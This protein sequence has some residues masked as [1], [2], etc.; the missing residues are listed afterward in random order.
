MGSVSIVSIALLALVVAS[1]WY[2]ISTAKNSGDFRRISAM[3]QYDSVLVT[4]VLTGYLLETILGPGTDLSAIALLIVLLAL[5]A[6]L[7][8]LF[9][10]RILA[11]LGSLILLFDE[12]N[13][14]PV[15][16]LFVLAFLASLFSGVALGAWVFRSLFAARI[17]SVV[18][19]RIVRESRW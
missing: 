9:E 12:N 19:D 3:C 11:L 14:L 6:S 1:F 18:T 13:P 2:R 5:A 17:G 8:S 4:L 15:N 16:A 10:F 7:L